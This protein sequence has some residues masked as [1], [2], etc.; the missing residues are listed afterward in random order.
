[1]SSPGRSESGRLRTIDSVT[2]MRSIPR[3]FPGSLLGNA[4]MAGRLVRRLPAYLKNSQTPEERESIVRR[5]LEQRADGFLRF[6]RRAVVEHAPSPY[7]KLLSHAGCEYGD[8]CN[9]VQLEG[10]EG[11]LEVLLS[12]GVYLT[13]DE[14]K[15]RVP[16][17]RGSLRFDVAQDHFRNPL[18]A[19]HLLAFTSGS[20]G[21][22]TS[23]GLDLEVVKERSVNLFLALRAWQADDCRMAIWTVRGLT[24]LLWFS[25]NGRPVERWFRHGA[26]SSPGLG[27]KFHWGRR[28]VTWTSHLAGAPLP[29]PQHVGVD[30]PAPVISWLSETLAHGHTPHLWSAPSSVVRVC[31]QAEAEGVDIRGARFTITGEPITGARLAIIERVGGDAAPDYGAAETGGSIAYGCRAP[32]APDDVHLFSDL[33]ALIQAEHSPFPPGALLVTTLRPL[34]PFV[35]LNVSLGDRATMETRACGCPM[36]RIGWRAHL[37]D[38]R[39]YEKLTAGGVSFEDT[40]IVEILESVLPARFGGGP[41]D[42]QLAEESGPDDQPRLRLLVHPAIGS[43]DETAVADA[44]LNALGAESD[45]SY[46]MACHLRSSAVLEV[47]RDAPRADGT[48]KIQHLVAAKRS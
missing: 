30:E 42:Y 26:S 24:P 19:T 35:M 9:L 37:R 48:G 22:P 16:V 45:T 6:M 13:I 44:F 14:F 25:G 21:T 28:A 46:E 5:R 32:S 29:V 17:E 4:R 23:I 12:Q 11:A 33:N 2:S 20:R 18:S 3:S 40:S 36:E 41:T 31:Q 15:G 27:G 10:V 47:V 38:I 34:A 39:S 7:Q 43:L 1:M 8:L